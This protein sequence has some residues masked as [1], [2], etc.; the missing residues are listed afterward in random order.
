[1][2]K[3]VADQRARQ[4]GAGRPVL[5][6]LVASLALLAVYMVGLLGWSGATT[7]TSPQQQSSQQ[8]ASP[9][10]SSSNTNK[11]PVDN[12]AYPAQAS[13]QSGTPGSSPAR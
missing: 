9:G 10:A 2:E 4:G 13:P 7:P 6:V 12:P 11:I 3:V 5:Y 8:Q 1:M